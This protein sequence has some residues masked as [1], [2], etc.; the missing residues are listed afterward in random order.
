MSKQKKKRGREEDVNK[1]F[2]K[3][4]RKMSELNETFTITTDD[5]EYGGRYAC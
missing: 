5:H 2:K 3:L 4:I 1:M